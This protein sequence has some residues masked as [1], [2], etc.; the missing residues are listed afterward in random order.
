MQTNHTMDEAVE[1][2][3][4]FERLFCDRP[5]ILGVGICKTPIGKFALNV[6]LQSERDGKALPKDFFGLDVITTVVGAIR[7]L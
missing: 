5:G 6:Q 4:T 1:I 3:K 7:A 2:Q